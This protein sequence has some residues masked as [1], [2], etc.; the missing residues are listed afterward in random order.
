MPTNY[1]EQK[2]WVLDRSSSCSSLF[3]HLT[4]WSLSK[5]HWTSRARLNSFPFDI[6]LSTIDKSVLSFQRTAPRYLI[7]RDMVGQWELGKFYVQITFCTIVLG[8]LLHIFNIIPK[9]RRLTFK[10]VGVV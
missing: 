9:K 7:N 2:R 10:R 4:F 6:R 3:S 5:C 8:W 1:I